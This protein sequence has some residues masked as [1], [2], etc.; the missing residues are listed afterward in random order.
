MRNNIES[1][2]FAE[3]E[4]SNISSSNKFFEDAYST[5]I[6]ENPRTN[7][8]S[9]QSRD[10]A[11]ADYN[12]MQPDSPEA[13]GGGVEAQRVQDV[14]K[15][16]KEWTKNQKDPA[17][18]TNKSGDEAQ[19]V[20]DLSKESGAWIP[21]RE[22]HAASGTE[23]EGVE[24]QKVD[25]LSKESKEKIHNRNSSERK[26]PQKEA[27]SPQKETDQ[28]PKPERALPQIELYDPLIVI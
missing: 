1:E 17:D 26:S 10:T 11:S 28:T 27:K 9:E 3:A 18:K 12:K 6:P 2:K 15:E 7:E 13:K 16:S 8:K 20:D 19:E 22:A 14:S 4:S 5:Q 25:D 23:S 21:N 24:A